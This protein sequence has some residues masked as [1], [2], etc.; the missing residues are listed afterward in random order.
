MRKSN[1]VHR[2]NHKLLE[3]E[4]VREEVYEYERVERA[5]TI[6]GYV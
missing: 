3:R 2:R 1:Y 4:R 5:V 6:L